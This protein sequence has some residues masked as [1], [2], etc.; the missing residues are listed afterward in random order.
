MQMPA[1]FLLE[2][3]RAHERRH[4]YQIRQEHFNVSSFVGPSACQPKKVKISTMLHDF[5]R[6][7]KEAL[8][9]R[10][11]NEC[12]A[13]EKLLRS[14]IGKLVKVRNALSRPYQKIKPTYTPALN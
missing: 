13:L 8:D 4:V 12:R 6:K 1:A 5:A 2:A 9:Q 11:D 3:M 7:Y 10:I 14:E